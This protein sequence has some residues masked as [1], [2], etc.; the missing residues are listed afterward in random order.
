MVAVRRAVTFAVRLRR[1][2]VAVSAAGLVGA[3][4]VS[5]SSA[6]GAKEPTPPCTKP[7]FVAGLRRGVTPLPHGQVIRPW[8]CAGRFAYAA[9]VVAGNE[10]TVLFRADGTRW[11]TAD[12]AKYCEDRSVPARIYQNAC[13]TN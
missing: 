9:V 11:E 1:L 7:A 2:A 12:R 10:L 5:V 4:G 3:A 8:A 6:S 13:N